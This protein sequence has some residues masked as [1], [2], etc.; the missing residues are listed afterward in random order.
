M[1]RLFDGFPRNDSPLKKELSDVVNLL[2]FLITIRKKERKKK[3]LCI[4]IKLHL[5]P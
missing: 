2:P 4:L 5:N 3:W 1:M